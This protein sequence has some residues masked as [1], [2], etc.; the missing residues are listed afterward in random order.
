[1]AGSSFLGFARTLDTRS[2][3]YPILRLDDEIGDAACA[4]YRTNKDY[5]G[6]SAATE[7][8]GQSAA[9]SASANDEAPPARCAAGEMRAAPARWAKFSRGEG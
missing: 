3:N 4:L 7:A 5:K 8:L 2:D 6:V 9:T 1:M